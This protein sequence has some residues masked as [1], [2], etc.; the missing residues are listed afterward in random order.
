MGI[1]LACFQSLYTYRESIVDLKLNFI[2]SFVD[3]IIL[4]ILNIYIP[5][6]FCSYKLAS[7]HWGVFSIMNTLQHQ[8]ASNAYDFK[9]ENGWKAWSFISHRSRYLNINSSWYPDCG[10]CKSHC[11]FLITSISNFITSFSALRR[12]CVS[13]WGSTASGESAMSTSPRVPCWD[14]AAT[15][16]ASTPGH[17]KWVTKIILGAY[18][19]CGLPKKPK[20]L[21]PAL[22]ITFYSLSS[23]ILSPGA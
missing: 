14:F 6:S 21:K 17:A 2:D 23:I 22:L 7:M 1:N 13:S 8:N 18:C 19:A 12:P 10:R 16:H 20:C 9:S 15:H 4:Y 5:F 11:H 3:L